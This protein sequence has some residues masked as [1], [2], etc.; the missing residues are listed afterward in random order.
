LTN[1]TACDFR[2]EATMANGRSRSSSSRRRTEEVRRR[3]AAF[4]GQCTFVKQP[5]TKV[6]GSR[7]PLKSS[8]GYNL[9]VG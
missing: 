2:S 9:R 3:D 6:R 8:L 5:A 4:S 7:A 1:C